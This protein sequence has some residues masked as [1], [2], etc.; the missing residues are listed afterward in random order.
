MKMSI[1][2]R[3]M[4]LPD[5]PYKWLGSRDLSSTLMWPHRADGHVTTIAMTSSTTYTPDRTGT[6]AVEV[7]IF[8][9][10]L[11]IIKDVVNIGGITTVIV[12]G[13]PVLGLA[14]ITLLLD[15]GLGLMDQ[16]GHHNQHILAETNSTRIL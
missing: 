9:V 10:I 14:A 5:Q 8:H 13:T 3:L 1:L 12:A 2:T 4:N 11:H 16:T 7:L 6:P 15:V